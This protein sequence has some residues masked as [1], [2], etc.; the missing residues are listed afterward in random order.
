[1]A[2]R[3]YKTLRERVTT[4]YYTLN[5]TLVACTLGWM[6][7]AWTDTKLWASLGVAV[8]LAYMLREANNRF[9]WIR[10]RS[11]MTSST[12]LVLATLCP[13]VHS[14]SWAWLPAF[15]L[16]TAYILLFRATQVQDSTALLFHAFAALSIGC[17]VLPQTMWLL[18]M[19]MWQTATRLRILSVR[20]FFAALLGIGLPL[21]MWFAWMVWNGTPEQTLQF[22]QPALTWQMPALDLLPQSQRFYMGFIA[23]CAFFGITHC[24]RA[25][26]RDKTAIRDI[27][28]LFIVHEILLLA[29]LF[30][31]PATYETI[32]PM[33]LLNTAPLL[34]H[35]FTL[36]RG[37][38]LM[39][40]WFDCWLI[41]FLL[42][43]IAPR[44]HWWG[45]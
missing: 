8:V 7:G 45:L 29:I 11:R 24:W 39:G 33:L 14:L 18:P 2:E 19:F 15:C 5:I 35:Y 6:A 9:Q 37:H 32:L 23:V 25:R 27:H 31:V 34:S 26:F 30:L 28:Y 4:H 44:L 42:V 16:L 12:F 17:F 22:L 38:W 41:G 10:V 20:G 13:A 43:W 40:I 1:M 3:H 36:A 21:W